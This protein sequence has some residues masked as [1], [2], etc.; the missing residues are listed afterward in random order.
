VGKFGFETTK[1]ACAASLLTALLLLHICLVLLSPQKLSDGSLNGARNFIRVMDLGNGGQVPPD[2]HNS[3]RDRFQMFFSMPFN[4][5][6]R[7][8]RIVNFSAPSDGSRGAETAG[9][10]DG[11]GSQ[12]EP[13]AEMV[14]RK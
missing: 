4:F 5:A 14:S 9:L 12:S 2:E 11:P 7:V 8:E 6:V 13:G 1:R 3:S 10:F